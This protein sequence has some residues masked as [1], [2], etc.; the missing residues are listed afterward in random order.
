MSEDGTVYLNGDD[1]KLITVDAVNGSKP[2]FFGMD[3]VNEVYAE[4]I[5]SRGLA[6]TDL[7]VVRGDIRF[8]VH[9]P[10]PGKHMVTN[11]LAAVAIGLDMGM[12]AEEISAGI[13]KFTPVGGHSSIVET[14]KFT[15]MDDCYN[16]NPVSMKAG[17][18]VLSEVESRKVAIIGDMFELGTDERELHFGVGEYA[19]QKGIDCVICVG[20][21]AK[22]YESAIKKSDKNIDIHYFEELENALEE[23]KNLV[24]DGDSILVKASHSMHFEKI[25]AVLKDM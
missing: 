18:D 9:V 14:E 4:N 6:G 23:I 16:A 7:D 5:V 11:A 10:V 2:V 12:T 17:I 8:A 19:A 22:E 20:T 15:I 21:L 13:K 25:V 24:K 1:D 3:S